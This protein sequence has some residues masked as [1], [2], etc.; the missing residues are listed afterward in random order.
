MSITYA[1]EKLHEAISRPETG[2]GQ[3]AVVEDGYIDEISRFCEKYDKLE[4]IKDQL[5]LLRK[6]Y[7]RDPSVRMNKTEARACV[8]TVYQYVTALET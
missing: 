4:G 8:E 2:H 5:Q 3:L 1:F 6:Y 7:S